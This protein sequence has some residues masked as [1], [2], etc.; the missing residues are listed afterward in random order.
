MKNRNKI[1]ALMMTALFAGA[2]TYDVP[3]L[4]EKP[5]QGTADFTKMIS[6]GNSL[7]AGFMNGALYT[8]SQNNSFVSIIARQMQEVGGSAT[9]NQ[10]TVNSTNGCYNPTGGCTAGRLYLVNTVNG[11]S[12]TPKPGDGGAGFAPLSTEARA[13]L[14]NFGV[15]GVTVGSAQ[16]P[17]LSASPYYS[18]IASNAGTSTLIGDA[19][20]ALANGGTFF[21]FW[22]GNNDVLG[23]ATAGASAGGTLTPTGTFET[24]FNSALNAMLDA[25]EEAKGA[26]ANIPN[27]TSIPFFSA[28]AWNRIA[29]STANAEALTT[30]LGDN[31]NAFLAGMVTNGIITEDEANYREFTFVAGNNGIM[32]NDETLTDLSPYMV[33]PYAGLSP[34]AIARQAKAADLICLTAGSYLGKDLNADSSP[35]MGVSVP[36]YNDTNGTTAALKGDDLVLLPHEQTAIQDAVDAFNEII[37]D[38]VAANSDRLVLVDTNAELVKIKTTSV[39]IKG[40]SLTAS[41]SPPNGAFSLDGVHPNARGSAYIANVFIKAINAKFGSNIPLC[42]PNTFA[43]NELPVT[44]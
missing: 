11:P 13:A 37:A 33:G 17:A 21:T 3:Q 30:Q 29:L 38:A 41:I 20:T 44:P 19:A 25:N 34:Y 22:L 16:S 7:T 14:N 15:P 26:V 12:P 8:E 23:Y 27:V 9:F 2:C 42:N 10:A 4:E 31:Y 5:T 1:S 39:L 36:L 35:D 6:V 43:G 32:I 24:Q 28:V 40:S 18:R